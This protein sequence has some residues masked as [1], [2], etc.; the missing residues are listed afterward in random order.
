MSK[1][2]PAQHLWEIKHPYYC[3]DGNYFARES[4]ETKYASWADFLAEE[5]DSDFDMNLVFRWD[6]RKAD[7][8]EKDWGNPTDELKLYWMGQ[9]KGLYRYSTI[10]VTDADES[11]IKAWLTQ[12]WNH[13]MRLW[14][15]V[16]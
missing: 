1:D 6:W 7:P 12:R 10:E 13:M 4:T 9:R 2:K 5:G 15:G 3:N 14:E 8:E 16:S 11:A